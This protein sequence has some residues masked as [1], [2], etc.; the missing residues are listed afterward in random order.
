MLGFEGARQ[1]SAA[2]TVN[3]TLTELILEGL[4]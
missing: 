2:L 3:T 4:Q 1:L